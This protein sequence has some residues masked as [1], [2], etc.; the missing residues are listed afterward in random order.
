MITLREC[1][2]TQQ[3]SPFWWK[4]VR[5]AGG[6]SSEQDANELSD[7]TQVVENLE[8]W[9]G[10]G[11]R[12]DELGLEAGRME[13]VWAGM[14]GRLASPLTWLR[15]CAGR[16]GAVVLPGLGVRF[17][18]EG[19]VK[20]RVELELHPDVADSAAFFELMV[21]QL[22][23]VPACLGM[24]P[25]VVRSEVVARRGH[26]EIELPLSRTPWAMLARLIQAWADSK[27]AA[28]RLA[29]QQTGLLDKVREVESL[30]KELLLVRDEERRRLAFDLH[31]GLGQVLTGIKLRAAAV[32][33]AVTCRADDAG[34]LAGELSM[35]AQQA[36]VQA[37]AL[38]SGLDP[39]G[40]LQGGLA[41]ALKRLASRVSA[42][43]GL[44]VEF[45]GEDAGELSRDLEE[46]W[47][48]IAQ[49]AL[50]NAVKHAVASRVMMTLKT[51]AEG[52]AEMRITDDGRGLAADR[53]NAA[54]MG[55]RIMEYRAAEAGCDFSI[56]S[57][58]GMGTAITC[59]WPAKRSA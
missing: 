9:R 46:A 24:P 14:L 13:S 20:A 38:S 7:W 41:P 25:A 4:A 55:L 40:E 42:M 30:Q 29:E 56:D 53:T 3:V 51:E 36:V 49:E 21:G 6:G 57:A 28:A 35:L 1:R 34:R 11:R 52:G 17:A 31:D 45:S 37:R 39:V 54:G 16:L 8:E 58:A 19:A 22:A 50:H 12:M 59:R 48:R 5:A 23:A 43:Y 2:E 33:D 10:G 18:A 44:A 47:Y 26:Y 15:L 32:G 27:T